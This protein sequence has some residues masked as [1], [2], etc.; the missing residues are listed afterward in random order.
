MITVL[1]RIAF[2]HNFFYLAV[3]GLLCLAG[4]V[5]AIKL[6]TRVRG[7]TG[8]RKH[9]WL[10]LTSAVGGS[11]LWAAHFTAMIGY[12]IPVER[13]FAIAPTIASLIIIIVAMGLGFF[14]SAQLDKRFAVEIGGLILG[15]GIA[16]MHYTGMAALTIAGSIGWNTTFVICSILS[17][18]LLGMLAMNRFARPCSR[19]CG[20]VSI[21][22]LMF[23][24]ASVHFTGMSAITLAPASG[25]RLSDALLHD[26]A[27]LAAMTTVVVIMILILGATYAIDQQGGRAAS[28]KYRYL[29]L[30]DPITG[31][32]NRAF[33]TD[34][35]ARNLANRD[36]SGTKAAIFFISLSQFK[37][38]NDLHGY[39]AGDEVLSALAANILGALTE[40]ETLARFN[41]D[42]FVAFKDNIR[43]PEEVTAFA[44]KIQEII[45]QPIHWNNYNLTLHASIG[46]AI[47]PEDSENLDTLVSRAALAAKEAKRTGDQQILTYVEGM[48]ECS[49]RQAAIAADLKTAISENQLDIY[50]QQ[51]NSTQTRE[52]IGY[53]AL[54]RWHHPEKG[55]ISAEDF[56]PIAERTGQILEIGKWVLETACEYAVG[57]KVPVSVS[58]NASPL[59]FSRGN[60]PDVVAQALAKTGLPPERLEIEL[61][62]SC[63]IQDHERVQKAI[64]ALRSLGVRVSMDDFGTGYSSLNTLQNF[65]FDKIKVDRVFTQSIESDPRSRAIIR[66]ALLLGHSF[67]IPVLAEG[68]ENEVQLRFLAEAGCTEVQGYLFGRP[69]PASEI[70][71]NETCP[72]RKPGRATTDADAADLKRYA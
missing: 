7:E 63:I 28:E 72:A 71:S 38:I 40:G 3:A 22:C 18:C 53:E 67:K 14:I 37:T 5:I 57:W 58:V 47:F 48:E 20:T 19:Y 4:S 21:A 23:A 30:H 6:C 43:G 35:I 9:L 34:E 29:A 31:L 54:L 2:E 26:G 41:G 49:R 61:T 25:A 46:I 17:G 13:A 50:F 32:P 39:Q 10:F 56:I 64:K 66:S 33:L 62:E 42:E 69:R 12:E 27:L 11:T 60:Y 51:Q 36:S 44:G 16:A 8:L 45:L 70:P 52:I 59:Q 55:Q 65:P 15:L 24:I 1:S 68:V